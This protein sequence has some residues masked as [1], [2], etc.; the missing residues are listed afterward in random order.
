MSNKCNGKC[1]G[2]C[3]D[4]QQKADVQSTKS[5]HDS[6]LDSLEKMRGIRNQN[7]EQKKGVD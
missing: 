4:C 3:K 2:N 5:E 7:R 6:I 1:N